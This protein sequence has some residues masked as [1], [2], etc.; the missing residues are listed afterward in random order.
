L[1]PRSGGTRQNFWIKIILQKTRGIGLLCVES[2][3]IL[4]SSGFDRS[5][6]VTDRGTDRRTDDST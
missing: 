3:V 4:T 5:T 2:C 1:T 6:R